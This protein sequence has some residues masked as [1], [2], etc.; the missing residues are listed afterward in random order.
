MDLDSTVAVRSCQRSNV[1][2]SAAIAS[3]D[4]TRSDLCSN[5]RAIMPQRSDR[6]DSSEMRAKG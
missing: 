4:N 3:G 6:V 5:I 1:S 2:S